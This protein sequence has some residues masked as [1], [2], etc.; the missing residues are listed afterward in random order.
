MNAFLW[1][2]T[3][4]KRIQTPAYALGFGVIRIRTIKFV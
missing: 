2:S 4:K 3:C 1:L